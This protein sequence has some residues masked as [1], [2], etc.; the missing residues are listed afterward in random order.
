MS[1]SKVTSKG[2]NAPLPKFIT[3]TGVDQWT[4][5]SGMV[6]LANDYPGLIEWALLFSPKRQGVEPRYPSLDFVRNLVIEVPGVYAAHLCGTAADDVLTVG[7]SPH[8]EL[9]CP[10]FSRAQINAN[11]QGYLEVVRRWADRLLVD[12]ILQCRSLFPDDEGISWLF[13]RS[14][15]RGVEQHLW[16]VTNNPE[17]LLGY[18]GGLNASN[19]ELKIADMVAETPLACY[20]IDMETG[21][22]DHQDR[23]SL[24]K[25][26]EVCQAVYGPPVS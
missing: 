25:C 12:P 15:G 16:P 14:G 22:R 5:P 18:A 10:Y 1:T 17:R 13:D 11:W 20:W 3:F 4:D 7:A 23:F 26:R 2:A 21:V 9:I 6:A 24:A 19:V 8:D